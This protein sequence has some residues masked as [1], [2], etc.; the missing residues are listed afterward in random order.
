MNDQPPLPPDDP[1]DAAPLKLPHS[2][3]TKS[4]RRRA[5]LTLTA[6]GVV[7]G[8]IGTSP[9]YALRQTALAAE[10]HVPLQSSI[11]GVVSLIVWSLVIVVTV[12]YVTLIM[13]ADNGGEGGELALASLAHRIQGLDRRTKAAIGTAAILGLSLFVG[14]G[15]LTPAISVLSAVEGLEVTSKAFAPLVVPLS[16]A[17]LIGLF[18]LQHRGTAHVGRLFGPVMVVWFLTIAALGV[19]SIAKTPQILLALSPHY[20]LMLFV[21]E[22]WTAF[23]ALGSVVLAVTGCET[24]YA[25][26]GH[27][28]KGPI[29]TAWIGFVLPSVLLNYFGQGAALLRDPHHAAI[30]FYAV[31]PGW[32]QYPLVLLATIA[33]II[34][35]QAVISGVFSITRQAVQLGMLPRMQIRHTSATDYGQIYVPRMNSVLATGVVLIVLIFKSSSALAAAYGIAVTGE[36]FISTM[37]VA[38]IALRQWHW[39]RWA[40]VGLFGLLGF[41]DLCFLGSNALKFVEGGWLPLFIAACVFIVMETWRLGRRAHL[42]RLRNESMPLNLFLERADKTP[43]RVA[44]TAV[45]LSARADGVPGALLHNL[46]HNKVLHVRVIICQV[47]VDDTP[48]AAPDKRLEVE[49]LGKG[50]FAVQIHHGFFETP[51]V[52]KALTEARAYGL[53]IDPETTTF[54]IGRETLL[55]AEHPALPRWRLWLYMKL[56]SNALSPARFYHLPPNRVVELGAQVTI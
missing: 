43:V 51:D 10:Q 29:R 45:F 44:G 11:F 52:P 41:I 37:L 9:L 3:E 49:K 15:M 39:N 25:D 20:G 36:M 26:M 18:A 35:S 32:A 7:F 5:F 47:V 40:V 33:T 2:P 1:L 42:D 13:R 46:K 34:A 55:P 24:L 16:L 4:L 22:P 19:A 27:F 56:A 30:A 53:A 38:M 17:I 54:F 31:A 12:K 23:V 14:D 8:D 48:F 6:L 21:R 28:G 50:F